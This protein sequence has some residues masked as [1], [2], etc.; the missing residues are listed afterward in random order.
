MKVATEKTRE[1][2]AAYD[3]LK[4]ERGVEPRTDDRQS[5]IH[6]H[7]GLALILLVRN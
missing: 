1:I 6:F 7:A 3:R 2:K 4:E 5:S